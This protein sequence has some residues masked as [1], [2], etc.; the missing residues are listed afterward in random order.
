MWALDIPKHISW[1]L[2]ELKKWEVH[3]VHGNEVISVVAGELHDELKWRLKTFESSAYYQ[4]SIQAVKDSLVSMF[5][6]EN[7]KMLLDKVNVEKVFWD[8]CR[9]NWSRLCKLPWCEALSETDLYRWDQVEKEFEWIRYKF[10]L[11]FCGA[12]VDCLWHNQHEFIETHTNLAGAGY[13]QKSSDGTDSWLEE[14]FGLLPGNSHRTFN[15]EGQAE[16]NWNPKY[17]MHRWL[18]GNT[19]NV[20]FVIEKY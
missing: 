19:G 17:P 2:K 15:I 8:F 16:E 12:D 14:T 5:T 4:W 7:E 13:M 6:I 20:W 1:E 9:E 18:G 11:W 3:N 10:N